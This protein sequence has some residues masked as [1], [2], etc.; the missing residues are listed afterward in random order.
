MVPTVHPEGIRLIT[1]RRTGISQAGRQAPP[2]SEI[3]VWISVAQ[4]SKGVWVGGIHHSLLAYKPSQ[5]LFQPGLLQH[6]TVCTMHRMLRI[7]QLP[8][9]R[10][11]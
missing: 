1:C 6:V 2:G 4:L 10:T 3:P 7:V 5:S 9:Y 8:L 11:K